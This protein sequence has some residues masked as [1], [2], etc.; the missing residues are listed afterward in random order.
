MYTFRLKDNKKST[1]ENMKSWKYLLHQIYYDYIIKYKAVPFFHVRIFESFNI[2][3]LF[4]CKN[5][6]PRVSSKNTRKF[7]LLIG[8]MH[9]H[10]IISVWVKTTGYHFKW[11]PI[12]VNL[13]KHNG[14]LSYCFL[15][16]NILFDIAWLSRKA[17]LQKILS[18]FR[19]L[20]LHII[21][22]VYLKF[23]LSDIQYGT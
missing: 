13:F 23:M 3:G 18:R 1:M 6:C 4:L 16:P 11:Q 9:N 14:H 15:G 20:K 8:H 19:G 2:K 21:C 12:Y 5:L 7:C 17:D 10:I 22:F